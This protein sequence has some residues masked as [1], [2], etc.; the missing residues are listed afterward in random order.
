MVDDKNNNRHHFS[1]ENFTNAVQFDYPTPS[2]EN[3]VRFHS[4]DKKNNIIEVTEKVRLLH[5]LILLS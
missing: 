1:L 5:Q 4:Y 2:I 3:R